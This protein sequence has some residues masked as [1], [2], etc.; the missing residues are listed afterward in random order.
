MDVLK[1]EEDQGVG[2]FVRMGAK[3]LLHNS[4]GGDG[5][6]GC[7]LSAKSLSGRVSGGGYFRLKK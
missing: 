6:E 5:K 7:E 3:M 4:Q 1:V 2:R